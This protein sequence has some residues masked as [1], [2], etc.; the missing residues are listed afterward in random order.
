MWL[1]LLE[2]ASITDNLG[3][4]PP[5][6]KLI[7][8]MTNLHHLDLSNNA[9]AM[10]RKYSLQ[11]LTMLALHSNHIRTLEARGFAGLPALTALDLSDNMISEVHSEALEGALFFFA[12]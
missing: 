10:V 4:T 8:H 9:L 3:L 12:N 11:K 6:L 2:K 5:L 1:T 7:Q